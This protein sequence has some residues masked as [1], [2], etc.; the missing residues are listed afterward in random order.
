MISLAPARGRE[1]A[2]VRPSGL[3]AMSEM[4]VP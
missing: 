2:I 3:S 1:A 4:S